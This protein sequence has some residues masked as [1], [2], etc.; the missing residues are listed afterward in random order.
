VLWEHFS[1]AFS[2]ATRHPEGIS[3]SRL[4][5]AISAMRYLLELNSN[6]HPSITYLQVYSIITTSNT[7]CCVSNR[8]T[9]RSSIV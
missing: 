5:L 7:M 8:C 6:P 3:H 9:T 1:T 4:L 2:R